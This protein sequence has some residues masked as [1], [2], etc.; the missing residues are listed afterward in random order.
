MSSSESINIFTIISLL[1]IA[2]CLIFCCR[3]Y[4]LSHRKYRKRQQTQFINQYYAPESQEQVFSIEMPY[5][6]PSNNEQ[7]YHRICVIDFHY[8]MKLL[9]YQYPINKK[10]FVLTETRTDM[11]SVTN[12]VDQMEHNY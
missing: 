3:G 7:N 12:D 8:L 4:M 10:Y 11:P 5:T 6:K 9:K 1:I 2:A